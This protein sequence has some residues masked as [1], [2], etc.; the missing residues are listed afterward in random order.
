MQ[1]LEVTVLLSFFIFRGHGS[2]YAA[3]N[4]YLQTQLGLC[5]K[6]D[7]TSNGVVALVA[8]WYWVLSMFLDEI[9]F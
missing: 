9:T 4:E 1:F 8:L 7:K 6:L 5:F 3:D 2:R